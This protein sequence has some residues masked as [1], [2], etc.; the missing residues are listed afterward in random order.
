MGG[1]TYCGLT[2]LITGITDFNKSLELSQMG[3]TKHVDMTVGDIYGGRDY[4]ALNLNADM[5]AS[6]FAKFINKDDASDAAS[7][8]IYFFIH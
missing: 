3:D 7:H 8:G 1:G 2:K 5:T 4:A 6:F